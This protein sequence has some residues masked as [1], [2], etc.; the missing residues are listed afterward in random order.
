[1]LIGHSIPFYHLDFRPSGQ[2][3]FQPRGRG[4]SGGRSCDFIQGPAALRKI[5]E[6]ATDTDL[7]D[8]K[9]ADWAEFYGTYEDTVAST[10]MGDSTCFWEIFSVCLTGDR[11]PRQYQIPYLCYFHKLSLI[12]MSI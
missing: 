9:L 6:G 3:Q 7:H 10:I 2:S 4:S 1:M 8:T 12:Y 11:P 5:A